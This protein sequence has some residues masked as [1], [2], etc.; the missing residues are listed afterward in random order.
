MS[1]KGLAY[2]SMFADRP[3]NFD[4]SVSDYMP[5]S[6]ALRT[7][8][9]LNDYASM[10]GRYTDSNGVVSGA[11]PSKAAFDAVD[12]SKAPAVFNE[13]GLFN[14]SLNEA[15]KVGGTGGG[16]AGSTSSAG[17]S[18]F[19]NPTGYSNWLEGMGI[20]ATTYA[21]YS[22]AEQVAI[23]ESFANL[24]TPESGGI[25]NKT[26][27]FLGSDAMKGVGTIAGMGFGLANIFNSMSAQKQ[28]KK[29]WEA[30]NARANELMAMNREKYNT[31]KADKARLN[32]QYA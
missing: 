11:M 10:Y 22:P 21:G 16:L 26:M 18:T 2:T 19:G 3:N 25:F 1:A 31:Y 30:E 32:S 27:D 20:D 6:T 5:G 7:S 24:Q 17:S 29:Q 28:A 13:K 15:S 12:V 4:I 9:N 8:N 23:G 14:W